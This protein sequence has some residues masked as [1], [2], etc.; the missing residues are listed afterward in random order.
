[1]SRI[2]Q[3]LE[4]EKIKPQETLTE[5]FMVEKE[6]LFSGLFLF[7]NFNI[8]HKQIRI[9]YGGMIYLN[10]HIVILCDSMP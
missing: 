3:V 1:M 9:I 6:A 8:Q 4:A 10:T 7:G 2:K 5:D